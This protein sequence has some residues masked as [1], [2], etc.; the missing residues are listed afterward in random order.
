MLKMELVTRYRWCIACPAQ[1]EL[2]YTWPEPLAFLSVN[3]LCIAA[4]PLPR[5]IFSPLKKTT[6]LSQILLPDSS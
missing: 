5:L 1:L 3:V 4:Y 2:K 6:F